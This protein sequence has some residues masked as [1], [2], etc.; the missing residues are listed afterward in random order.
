MVTL[1]LLADLYDPSLVISH[2][3]VGP[4]RRRFD[5]SS[6]PA[7]AV[8]PWL[9]RILVVVFLTALVVTPLTLISARSVPPSAT[10]PGAAPGSTAPR[11]ARAREAGD[12]T[13]R[14]F[15]ASSQE[16]ARA[17]AAYQRA[18]ARA[19]GPDAGAASVG[20]A[21]SSAPAATQTAV[22]PQAQQLSGP[23]AAAVQRAA[24]VGQASQAWA[25]TR[26]AAAQRR[27]AAASARAQARAQRAAARGD[28]AAAGTSGT[29][30]T[31]PTTSA[32]SS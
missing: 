20:P 16:I 12:P 26:A 15:T 21:G 13:P 3:Y 10:A 19:G 7:P 27:A 32:G 22:G 5:R 2:G 25:A 30:G 9:H 31:P 11:S 17:D 8:P 1:E 23:S 14:V 28:G 4:D 6:P 18:L 29:D 24:A